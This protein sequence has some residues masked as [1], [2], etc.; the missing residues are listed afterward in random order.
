MVP[1]E[2]PPDDPTSDYM[3]LLGMVFSMFGL[4]MKV[5]LLF[6]FWFLTLAFIELS[7]LCL[8]IASGDIVIKPD[9]VRLDSRT[10]S[11]F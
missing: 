1:E 2:A 6:S 4:M 8:K 10:T 7:F 3:N 5:S 9:K 11:S